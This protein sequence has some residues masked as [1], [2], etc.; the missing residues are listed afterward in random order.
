MHL[1]NVKAYLNGGG[2]R[3]Y[4]CLVILAIPDLLHEKTGAEHFVNVPASSRNSA[5]YKLTF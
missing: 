1:G 4:D 2:R 3:P 5:C